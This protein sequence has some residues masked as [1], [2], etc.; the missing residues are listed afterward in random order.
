MRDAPEADVCPR[1]QKCERWRAAP[2]YIRDP[3]LLWERFPCPPP[4]TDHARL[5]IELDWTGELGNEDGC[6]A[7][8]KVAKRCHVE[9]KQFNSMTSL[10]ECDVLYEAVVFCGLN[11][12]IAVILACICVLFCLV[13][14]LV[15]VRYV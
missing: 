5:L 7:F 2:D 13:L 8:K 4:G 9:I 10:P 3:M 1:C 14:V 11:C 12:I 15:C 6:E